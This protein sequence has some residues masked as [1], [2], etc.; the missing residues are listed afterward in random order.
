MR[1]KAKDYQF[2]TSY[3]TLEEANKVISDDV[4]WAKRNEHQS[5]GGE[6]S[7]KIFYLCKLAKS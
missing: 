5:K 7:K 1:A 4:I 3:A 2:C 6:Y